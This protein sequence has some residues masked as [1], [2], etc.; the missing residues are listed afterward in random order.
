MNAI[1]EGVENAMRLQGLYVTNNTLLQKDNMLTQLVAVTGEWVSVMR[2]GLQT[3]IT[4]KYNE[5]AT[6]IEGAVRWGDSKANTKDITE[7]SL[8]NTDQNTYAPAI[9][10]P[11]RNND[12]LKTI[13]SGVEHIVSAAANTS[14]TATKI[15][16]TDEVSEWLNKEHTM[17][18]HVNAVLESTRTKAVITPDVFGVSDV[19]LSV[20]AKRGGLYQH[21]EDLNNRQQEKGTGVKSE[22]SHFAN[23]Y[24]EFENNANTF[25]NDWIEVYKRVIVTELDKN[26]S[27]N[28]YA[29]MMRQYGDQ[30]HKQGQ[31]HIK[32]DI[33][34]LLP[35]VPIATIT[36]DKAIP[37]AKETWQDVI[38]RHSTL[39]NTVQTNEL[40][41][42][43]KNSFDDIDRAKKYG[44]L[45]NSKAT[46]LF[47]QPEQTA[48]ADL[49][50]TANK[51]GNNK[52]DVQY[53]HRG[54][55]INK[56]LP[57]KGNNHKSE[58]IYDRALYITCKQ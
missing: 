25:S 1:I 12:G 9:I 39:I 29:V 3:L 49:Y 33:D 32:L 16:A 8:L 30:S 20:E 22:L 34:S 35:E 10:P 48:Q 45:D 15:N 28:I 5:S 38:P 56:P 55:H 6:R 13:N 23:S 24:T 4:N 52:Q 26:L 46:D 17:Y 53:L 36:N 57:E 11:Y 51:N 7:H 44:Y 19:T 40:E 43:V 47:M 18:L 14:H 54:T 37:I 21:A 2:E 41:E 58:Q 31:E 42:F 27:S 50:P